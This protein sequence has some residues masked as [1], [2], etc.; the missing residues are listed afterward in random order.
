MISISHHQLIY[1]EHEQALGHARFA[2]HH[3]T[4]KATLADE[5][6]QHIEHWVIQRN[7]PIAG[8]SNRH[9]ATRKQAG[10]RGEDAAGTPPTH[11]NKERCAPLCAL[12]GRCGTAALLRLPTTAVTTRRKFLPK[13]AVCTDHGPGHLPVHVFKE[14]TLVLDPA[15]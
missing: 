7:T 9:T 2:E 15:S 3:F 1:H 14:L 13:V 11:H 8:I 4:R 6:R 10:K 12:C 5:C